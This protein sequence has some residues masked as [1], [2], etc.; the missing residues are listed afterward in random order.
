MEIEFSTKHMKLWECLSSSTRV[1]MIELLRDKPMNL[2]ELADK[3]GIST[4]IISRHVQQL[5]LAGLLASDSAPGERGRQKICRLLH[6]RITIV[7]RQ[8]AEVALDV[9]PIDEENVY[10]VSIP[11]GHYSNFQVK[12]T[13]GLASSNKLIGM[14]DDPRYFADPEH[15]DAQHLWFASGFIEY[16]I[17]NYL[18]SK[19]KPVSLRV[20][21]EIGS[22]APGFNEEW[23]SDIEFSVNGIPVGKWTSPG[24]F[25]SSKGLLNPPWWG[26]GDSQHGS[27]KTLLVAEEG[28]FIDGVMISNV[29]IS[30]LGIQPGGEINF[31]ITSSEAASHPGG[32]S[33]FGRQFGNYPHDIEVM[34]RYEPY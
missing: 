6:D 31:R 18:I 29:C 33:L 27:Q 13:C 21:L 30:D 5:E 1:R 14:V 19:T 34:I 12:P 25:G 28:A 4:A 24:D 20:T 15:V 26:K 7:F 3:L 11:V 2:R 17:P 23:P 32:V 10:G 22:E 8:S 9:G 16:R